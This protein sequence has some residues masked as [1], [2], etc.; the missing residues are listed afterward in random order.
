MTTSAPVTPERIMQFAWGYVPPLVLEAAVRHRVFDVLDSGSKTLAQV[1]N[2]TG[3][4]ERGLTAVMHALVGM[5][6]LA[7][8]K[9][10]LFSLTP[11]SSTF[12]VSTKPSFQG[13]LLRHG[14]EQLIPKWL[15]LNKIVET[16]RPVAAVNLEEAGGDFFQRFVVDI[17]PL[18]YP[19]AQALS[20]HLSADTGDQGFRP[21]CGFRRLE[22]SARARLGKSNCDGCGLARGYSDHPENGKQIRA[23]RALFIRRGRPAA[24]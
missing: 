7:K 11:E 15:H 9:Q 16:G 1:Q 13:G 5:G 24:G 18:S 10:G 22:H 20:R 4:S 19:A 14:S 17:F 2:E 12:L 3:A 6:F 21:G 8:D 23:G